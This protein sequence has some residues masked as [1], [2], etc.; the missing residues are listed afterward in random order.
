MARESQSWLAMQRQVCKQAL[1]DMWRRPLGNVLT[2]AVLTVA[3][4]L[5]T[6]F[7]IA[8]KNISLVSQAWQ[9]PTQLTVYLASGTGDRE[10]RQ[11]LERVSGWQEVAQTDYISPQQGLEEFRNHAGF[12]KALSLLDENPLPAVLVIKPAAQWQTSEAAAGLADKLRAQAGVDDV[13]LDS[14]WLQRLEAI[15]QLSV[16]LAML[17][18][19]LMLLA[20]FL[21]VGNTLRLQLQN[22]KEAVQVMKLVGA[23]NTYI[24]RPFLYTGAWYGLLASAL[25]LVLTTLVCLMI[26]SA[27][28]KLALL[29]GSD[30]HLTGLAWDEG[31]LLLM[32]SSLLGVLAA[33]L[34]A[35]R[36]LKEIEPI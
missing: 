11:L 5:P 30:F 25:A 18:A 14:D 32:L 22:Q 26:E 19:G 17:M 7:Y 33:R 31:L 35:G 27:V 15:K 12:A 28:D 24:L 2:L 13:R 34:S 3:L 8:A 29:Y 21:I 9:N 10:A 4:T 1:T 36:H 20:V 6:C 23:T 16:T